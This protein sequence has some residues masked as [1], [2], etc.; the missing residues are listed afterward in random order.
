MRS[1]IVS[2]L[3]VTALCL[4]ACGGSDDAESFATL[5]DC[6]DDHHNEE[7]LP[8]LEAIAVCCL[9]HPIAGVSPACKDTQAAC[10]AFVDAEL[11]ASVS[12]ADITAACADYIS[13]KDM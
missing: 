8:V 13:Q 1:L 6:Y 10:E 9:D 12:A 2:S 7:A 4:P 3:L 11:D 5:Q